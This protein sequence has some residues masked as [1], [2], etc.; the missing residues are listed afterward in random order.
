MLV[1]WRRGSEKRETA[2]FCPREMRMGW[3]RGEKSSR[4]RETETKRE[5]DRDRRWNHGSMDVKCLGI[6][7]CNN[8]RVLYNGTEIL[9]YF[10]N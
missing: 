7:G 4:D 10:Y 6:W 1:V 5:M 8:Q 9:L 3:W 2:D